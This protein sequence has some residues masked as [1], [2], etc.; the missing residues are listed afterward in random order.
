MKLLHSRGGFG[1]AI[2]FAMIAALGSAGATSIKPIS[3]ETLTQRA[4]LVVEARAEKSWAQWNP[5]HSLIFTYTRF[6]V[7]R[8]LKGNA[9][10]ELIVRQLGGSAGGYTQH[11]AGIYHWQ[12][13]EEAV[14]FLRP[15]QAQDGSMSV[16]GLMQGNFVVR[17]LPEGD[18]VASNGVLEVETYNP[19]QQAPQPYSGTSIRL[20]DLERRILK[21]MAVQP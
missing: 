16:V 19:G 10:A 14:L 5:Q 8:E 6:T 2:L 17:R 12:P 15:S 7:S 3:I 20:S 18:A 1:G 21:V 11:V 13:Q 9:P 4:R